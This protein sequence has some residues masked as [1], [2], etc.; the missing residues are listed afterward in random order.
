MKNTK[1]IAKVAATLLLFLM[2]YSHLAIANVQWQSC[3]EKNKPEDYVTRCATIDVPLWH[4]KQG[5]VER[6]PLPVKWIK[7]TS[8]QRQKPVILGINGGPGISNLSFKPPKELLD[9]FEILLV[10]FRGVDGKLNIQ[11]NEFEAGLSASP[12]LLTA[13]SV[14][15]MQNAMGACFKRYQQQGVDLGAINPEQTIEDFEFVRRLLNI[16]KLHILAGSFGTR[17]AMYYMSRFPESVDRAVLVAANPPGRT[18]WSPQMIDLKFDQFGMNC[19][20]SEDCILPDGSMS[21]ITASILQSLPDDILGVEFD[22]V[23]SQ[24]STFSMMYATDSA[25]L[26]LNAWAQAEKGRYMELAILAWLHDSLVAGQLSW[27]HLL[28]MAT[29][30]DHNPDFAPIE[31]LKSSNTSFGSPLSALLFS[32]MPPEFV[33]P[34]SLDISTIQH[35]TLIVSGDLDVSTPLEVADAEAML[36][37]KDAQHLKVQNAGHYDLWRKPVRQVFG[38]FYLAK[39]IK[40]EIPLPQP[41]WERLSIS[42]LIYLGL[43]AMTAILLLLVYLSRRLYVWLNR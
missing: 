39:E 35:P 20:Q 43:A 2:S 29:A 1:L 27:G 4:S 25:T 16:E 10:G 6:I 28:L 14:K 40:T 19:R 30:V 21:Q 18:I 34:I 37:F 33:S 22:P 7:K 36:L 15:V 41:N 17:L 38:E 31:T 3:Q 26:A 42:Q 5:S 11:C 12:K 13:H 8:A 9:D 24:I 23:R 32:A